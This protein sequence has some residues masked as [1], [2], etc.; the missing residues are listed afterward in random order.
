ME[1]YEN[2]EDTYDHMHHTGLPRPSQAG[3]HSLDRDGLP[4]PSHGSMD[5]NTYVP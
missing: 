1:L 4:R 2:E 5:L 3:T